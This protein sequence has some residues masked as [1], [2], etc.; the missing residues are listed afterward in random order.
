M[1]GTF[2]NEVAHLKQWINLRM[3]F[4]DRQLYAPVAGDVNG[5]GEL[6]IADLTMLADL[7]RN[8]DSNK[9][10]DVNGD[11]ETSIA[12]ATTLVALLMDRDSDAT[13]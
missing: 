3:Q 11:H 5:D 1:G 13:D 9:R 2:A 8:Q 12:D 4:M 10:S 6:S 7:V